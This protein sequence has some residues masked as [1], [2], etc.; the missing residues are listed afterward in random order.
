[1]LHFQ[2]FWIRIQYASGG[3]NQILINLFTWYNILYI[4]FS[5]LQCYQVTIESEHTICFQMY[6]YF[7]QRIYYPI[8]LNYFFL[9]ILIYKETV[10]SIFVKI[11]HWASGIC[12]QMLC[13]ISAQGTIMLLFE[14]YIRLMVTVTQGNV[15]PSSKK[16][17]GKQ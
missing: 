14:R 13:D 11:I 5:L 3:E 9:W 6:L 7:E 12:F 16:T 17:H 8:L 4:S 10:L 1:M 15:M 2:E